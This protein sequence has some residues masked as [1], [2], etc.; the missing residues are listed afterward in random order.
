MKV[1]KT[2]W[3]GHVNND[4]DKWTSVESRNKRMCIQPTNSCQKLQVYTIRKIS[5]NDIQ[6]VVFPYTME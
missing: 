4:T 3:N 5:S 6:K 2:V 1:I